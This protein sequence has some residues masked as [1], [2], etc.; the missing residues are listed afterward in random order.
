VRLRQDRAGGMTATSW[1]RDP[2]MLVSVAVGQRAALDK[3]VPATVPVATAGR[4]RL[5]VGH[6]ATP[7]ETDLSPT[8]RKALCGY[9]A[10]AAGLHPV[11]PLD[12]RLLPLCR[13][14]KT[15]LAERG[16]DLTPNRR[17]RAAWC[18]AEMLTA[19]ARRDTQR[20][21]AVRLIALD[22]RVQ[23]VP[24]QWLPGSTR[25]V[26][27][28]TLMA[29]WS[30]GKASQDAAL[31]RL[32]QRARAALAGERADRGGRYRNGRALTGGRR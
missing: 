11:D 15:R 13:R 30:G 3:L 18:Q 31:D 28:T 27:L 23:S 17:E 24:G 21:D 1:P 12:A 19:A 14:C 22:A 25:E 16:A 29:I 6:L 32:G 7:A 2:T 10:R 9:R 5:R 4:T 20:R 26:P 8:A